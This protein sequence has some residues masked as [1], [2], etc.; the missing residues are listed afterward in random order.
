M[1]TQ[2]EQLLAMAQAQVTALTTKKA[3]EDA[4][5]TS[6]SE[7]VR[8]LAVAIHTG[9]CT[10]NHSSNLNDCHWFTIPNQDDA[11]L[12]DWTERDHALWLDR[13]RL[14]IG[15]MRQLGFTVTGD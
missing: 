8:G 2:T 4:A 1:P 9:M 5:M 14:G 6:S 15:A 3:A 12:A 13:A 7:R 10:L 11:N